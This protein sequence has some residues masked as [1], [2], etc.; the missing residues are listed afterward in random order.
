MPSTEIEKRRLA[1]CIA[2]PCIDNQLQMT[3]NVL[4]VNTHGKVWNYLCAVL[5]IINDLLAIKI[6]YRVHSIC[7]LYATRVIQL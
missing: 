1:S 2:I 5:Y 4:I 6:P 7:N 3:K